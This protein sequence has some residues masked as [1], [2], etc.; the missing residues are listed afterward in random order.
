[1]ANCFES[2]RFVQFWDASLKFDTLYSLVFKYNVSFTNVYYYAFLH[3]RWCQSVSY[4]KLMLKKSQLLILD[5]ISCLWSFCVTN[6]RGSEEQKEGQ[7]EMGT[8]CV[9]TL[10]SPIHAFFISHDSELH[11]LKGTFCIFVTVVHNNALFM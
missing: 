9:R 5:Q 8:S 7:P 3:I 6:A 10:I 11:F 1:M 4:C 2:G